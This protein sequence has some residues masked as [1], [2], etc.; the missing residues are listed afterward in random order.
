MP[1]QPTYPSVYIDEIPGSIRTISGVAT[2]ITAFIGSALSGPVNEPTSIY[3]F[4][5]YERI[6]GGLIPESTM[7]YAVRNFYL[8][9][10]SKSI[11]VRIV[12]NATTARITLPTGSL[13]MQDSDLTLEASSP[14]AWGNKLTAE[15]N[16]NT[17]DA[18]TPLTSASVPD[19]PDL[20]NLIIYFD[21]I[22]SE[23]HLN[24]SLKES[25][26]N[27][28]S[29][30]LEKNSSLITVLRDGSG[31][32]IVPDSRPIVTGISIPGSGGSDGNDLTSNE[33]LGNETLKT[34]IYAFSKTDL[35]NLL[36]IPPPTRHADT[37]PTVYLSALKMCVDKRAMLLVDSPYAWG[38]SPATAA[39]NAM[40]GLTEL[41]LLSDEARNAALYFPRVKQADPNNEGM[42]D[43]FVP[44]GI[45]A[46]IIARTDET[47][48]VWKSPAGNDAALT[49]ITGLQIILTDK[50]NGRLNPL[51]INCLRSFPVTGRVIWGARTLRGTDQL[52]DDFKYIAVRRTAL[53]IE[54]SL[55]RGTKWAVFEPNDESLWAKIRLNVGAFMHNLFRQG[56]FQ[57]ATPKEAFLVNCSKETTTQYDINNG[58]VNILVGFAPLKPAEFIFIKIQQIAGQIESQ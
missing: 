44:C 26:L 3:N 15:V 12:L 20:F 30:I 10:G 40:S 32:R 46:G 33:Y 49:G 34:G 56:A 8:N 53:F 55:Y 54:E 42:I 11:I 1:I 47:R 16:Y 18:K 36:C 27:Y 14:G 25:G 51:G 52:A 7:S 41:G 48:G 45:I 35:F 23:E 9:G 6:F 31:N 58:I 38:A 2:S 4:S 19:N 50:E 21:G 22:K 57:G 37:D 29:H 17:T 39:A 28:L 13:S 24:V 5:D 43:T